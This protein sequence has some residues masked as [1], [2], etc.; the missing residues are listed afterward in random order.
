M[1]ITIN[2]CPF[3]HY[4]GTGVVSSE[5]CLLNETFASLDFFREG[6]TKYVCQNVLAT[7][8]PVVRVQLSFSRFCHHFENMRK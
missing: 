7:V 6:T 4:L 5:Q 8:R 3:L 2:L 1:I